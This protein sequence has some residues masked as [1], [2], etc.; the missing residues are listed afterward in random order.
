MHVAYVCAD[1]GVPVFGAKGCSVHVQEMLRA[2]R[3]QGCRVSLFAARHGG[4]PPADLADIPLHR[5]PRPVERHRRHRERACLAANEALADALHRHGPFDLVY[6]RYALWSHAGMSYAR[7]TGTPGLLEVNAP[8]I[9]EQATHRGLVDRPGAEQVA[10]T[11]FGAATALLAVSR[12]VAAYLN[13]FV[14][15]RGRVHVVPNG[16]DP[17][18]FRPDVAPAPSVASARHFTVGFAGS[19]KPWHGLP[20]LAE[21]FARLRRH[22]PEARLL[23]VGDGPERPA[24]ERQ[25]HD[26]GVHAATRF[27]GKVA[28]AHMPGLLAAMDVAVAPY[29]ALRDCYFSPLKIFEYMAA[30]R[31]VVASRIG[32]IPEVVR[33]GQTGLLCPPGDAATLA[34]ALDALRRDPARRRCLGTAARQQV[35]RH[36]TWE[37]IA[38]HV[39]DLSQRSHN[40][41]A[42]TV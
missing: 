31:P 25:L 34:E 5:L 40:Q 13:G 32:Q 18:R 1:P 29:P 7:L 8:L 3:A 39:L 6:E 23:L 2:F 33:H 28:P 42:E 36:H 20:V 21:A 19:L 27:T 12:A 22:A 10:R 38:R 30:G 37:A 24:L 16:V 35:L 4:P 41:P 9:D 15:A 14:E 17:R 26:L 11:A